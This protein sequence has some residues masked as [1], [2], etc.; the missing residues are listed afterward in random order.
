MEPI[1]AAPQRGQRGR[2]KVCAHAVVLQDNAAE[3][4]S[5]GRCVIRNLLFF[6]LTVDVFV[7]VLHMHWWIQRG[8]VGYPTPIFEKTKK[9]NTEEVP[10]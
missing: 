3:L 8:V 6:K 10:C 5:T 4:Y 2:A 7:H 9:Q 1:L